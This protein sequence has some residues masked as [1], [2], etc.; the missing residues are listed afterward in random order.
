MKPDNELHARAGY[1]ARMAMGY[2]KR[3]GL[4]KRRLKADEDPLAWWCL[5]ETIVDFA[6]WA[7]SK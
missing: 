4:E 1:L 6:K 2:E 5:T 7:E 3:N